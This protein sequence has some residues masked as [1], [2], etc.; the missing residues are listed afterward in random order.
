MLRRKKE[1]LAWAEV[2]QFYNSHQETIMASINHHQRG[3]THMSSKTKGKQRAASQEL[4]DLEPWE[5]EL[6]STFLG[7]DAI[8]LA[9]GFV[10]QGVEGV[11]KGPYRRE[12]I[13]YLVRYVQYCLTSANNCL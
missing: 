10:S 6:P 1:D 4:E 11:G 7:P 3:R 13:L 12:D 5:D 8:G 2:A 9:K